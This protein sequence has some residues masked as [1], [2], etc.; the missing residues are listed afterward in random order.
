MAIPGVGVRSFIGLAEETTYGTPVA[1]TKFLDIV[2]ES[3]A[4]REA[5]LES[6]ALGRVGILNTRFVQ[7]Q[8]SVEGD[9]VIEAT[10]DGWELLAKH[11]FGSVATTQPDPTNA[12]AGY[13]HV[14]T[15]ADQLPTGLTI[16]AFRD[17]SQFV[18]EPNKSFQYSGCK[19]ESLT[20]ENSAEDLLR[21]T[22]SIMG[23]DEARVAKGSESFSS[24]KVIPYH[25]GVLTWDGTDIEVEDW[26]I[27]LN[28]NLGTRPKLNS[29]VTREPVR[30]AKLEVVGSFTTEFSSW[31]QYDDFRNA[32]ERE[33][34]ITYTGDTIGGSVAKTVKLECGVAVL[35]DETVVAAAPGRILIDQSF[36]AYRTTSANEL[37]LTMIN[38]TATV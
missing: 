17:S 33:M 36:K 30:D 13:Q 27:S 16:E 25:Q 31:A 35:T 14:F 19:I 7:G 4:E 8:K 38:E 10:F 28:N 24:E 34:I 18:T 21:V 3:L 5:R 37:I 9:I 20:F 23:Q 2:S 15:I 22:A 6:A 12:A 26:S 1:S 11:G 32:T 29:R